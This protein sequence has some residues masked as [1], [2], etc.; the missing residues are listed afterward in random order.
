MTELIGKSVDFGRVGFF[1]L[2]LKTLKTLNFFRVFSVFSGSF[3]NA[4]GFNAHYSNKFCH[5][6]E[7]DST[8]NIGT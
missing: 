7:L 2:P 4:R 3:K 5:T 6:L 1:D 8:K